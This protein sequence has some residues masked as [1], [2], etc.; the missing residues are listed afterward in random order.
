MEDCG[1][2]LERETE[3]GG[4]GAAGAQGG[5]HRPSTARKSLAGSIL[6][7]ENMSDQ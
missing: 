5:R 4:I 6:F 2:I 1:R 7:V 3:R